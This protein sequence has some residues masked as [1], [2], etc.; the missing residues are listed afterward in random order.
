MNDILHHQNLTSGFERAEE[1]LVDFDRLFSETGVDLSESNRVEQK[2]EG[3]LM[4]IS[5]L[6]TA[7][8]LAGVAGMAAVVTA[9]ALGVSS[10]TGQASAMYPQFVRPSDPSENHRSETRTETRTTE[11]HTTETRT[12]E[13]HTTEPSETRT[14]ETRTTET[15]TTEP[16]ETRT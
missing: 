13:T 10:G 9:V 1:S 6:V 12:T 7:K 4:I 16:S 8:K 3:G 11:T 5:R 2:S 14:T 15:H